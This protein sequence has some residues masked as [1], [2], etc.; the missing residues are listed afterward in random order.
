M[1]SKSDVTVAAP[2]QALPEI[3]ATQEACTVQA[4]TDVADKGGWTEVKP[5]G[6]NNIS[7][8]KNRRRNKAKTDRGSPGR[9]VAR[10]WTSGRGNSM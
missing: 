3:P 10:C 6:D 9:C 5:R 7:N 4:G 2:S 8:G 1:S